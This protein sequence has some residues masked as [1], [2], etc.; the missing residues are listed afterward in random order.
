MDGEEVMCPSWRCACWHTLNARPG[1][2]PETPCDY[3]TTGVTAPTSPPARST[4]TCHRQIGRSE[5]R[6]ESSKRSVAWAPSGRDVPGKFRGRRYC[7]RSECRDARRN[8][9]Y[10]RDGPMRVLCCLTC[11]HTRRTSRSDVR[12][13]SGRRPAPPGGAPSRRPLWQV[14]AEGG[15]NTSAGATRLF[16][17]FARD[18]TGRAVRGPGN[19]AGRTVGKSWHYYIYARYE[20]NNCPM[21]TQNGV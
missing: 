10:G 14:L 9:R 15:L 12:K 21:R 7:R 19:I 5:R 16:G 2:Y 6:R 18:G 4:P 13:V 8:R 20:L 3:Q 11:T 17:A 1:V